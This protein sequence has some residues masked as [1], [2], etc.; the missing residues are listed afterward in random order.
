[1]TVAAPAKVNLRLRVLGRDA[2][3][4]HGVETIFLRLG[5]ADDLQLEI[6]SSPG[7]ELRLE[8]ADPADETVPSGP[9]NLAWRAAELLLSTVGS[10]AGVGIHLVKRIPAGSGLGGASSDAAAVLVA[11]NERLGGPLGPDALLEIGG[12]LGSDVPF[13]LLPHAMALGWERGRGLLPLRAPPARPA[14]VLVPRFAIRSG[15]AYAWLDERRAARGEPPPVASVLP[16]AARLSEWDS[17]RALALNDFEDI[18][19]E[20]HPPLA[21]WK[22]TLREAGAEIALLSGSGS[23]LFAIFPSETERDA[24]AERFDREPAVRTLRTTT[25][26]E[27]AGAADSR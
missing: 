18:A 11:L 3:G 7:I 5:L 25:V 12:Q 20:R 19:F 13:F 22:N 27:P 1:V 24:A 2:G 4:Y 9:G 23:A 10:D 21:G 6:T 16:A 14:L 17:L 8:L 26:S 15:Q